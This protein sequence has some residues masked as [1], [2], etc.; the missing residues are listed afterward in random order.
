[1]IGERVVSYRAAAQHLGISIKA[2][3]RRV[4]RKSI[5]HRRRLGSTTV[6]FDLDVIDAWLAGEPVMPVRKRRAA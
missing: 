2:L 5:P 6:M 1:M 3:R 4:E